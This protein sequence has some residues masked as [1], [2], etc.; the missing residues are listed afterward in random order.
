M[1]NSRLDREEFFGQW[2]ALHGGAQIKGI[3]RAWLTISFALCRSLSKLRITPNGL[4]Y[5]SLV[6]AGFY[7]YFIDSHW[8]IAF[9]VLSLMAD[10]LD[11][12]LAIITG[13]V[14]RWGAALD[15]VVDR[16]VES[17][18]AI[19]LF[20]LGAPW[21]FVLAAWLAAFSQEYMR[22]RAGGLGIQE[23]GVV[24]I[25]ERPVRATFIF[26]ALIGRVFGLD[27]V[28]VVSGIWMVMQVISAFTVLKVLRPLLQQSQR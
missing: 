6:F 1:S 15:S 28:G 5:I 4:T 11:G 21:Q 12:T 25:S 9:L 22:A 27:I 7:L 18:W 19:G 16:I 8:A 23:I 14:T 2:S 10:G 3:V 13:R 20:H 24:T 17:L 26:I